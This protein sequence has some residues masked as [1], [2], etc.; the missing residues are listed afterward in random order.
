MKHIYSYL[1]IIGVLFLTFTNKSFAQEQEIKAAA[2]RTL[3][4]GDSH[5]KDALN[6]YM[7]ASQHIKREIP[8]INYVRDIK[9]AQL[10]V[11]TTRQRT[12]SWGRQTNFF[13]EGQLDMAGRKDTLKY[14]SSPDDTED[15]IREG[16]I[17]TLKMGLMR[18]I[19]ETPLAEYIDIK[20]TE[21]ISEVVSDDKWDSWVFS[22]FLGGNAGGESKRFSY[23]ANTGLS[24]NR[25]TDE[26]R[27]STGANYKWDFTQYYI[28]DDTIKSDRRN[29]GLNVTLVKSLSEHFSAGLFTSLNTSSYNN[30]KLNFSLFPAIEYNIF[31]YS[32][33]TRRQLRL[34]YGLG[35]GYRDYHE[36]TIYDKGQ[37]TLFSH[38]VWANYRLIQKWGSINV[39]ANWANYLHDWSKNHLT[40]GLGFNFRIVKGLNLHFGGNYTRVRDQLALVKGG[41][42]EQEI[43]LHIKQLETSFNYRT[44]FG[45]S[46]TFGSIYSNV[47]NPRFGIGDDFD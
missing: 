2:E 31:P 20:F 42:T 11:I 24:A 3:S 30:F 15:E 32:E 5:R 26:W 19:L 38:Q 45:I 44:W 34:V 40:A 6:V 43:L 27:I 21:P 41:A 33:S 7:D 16:E 10:V 28:Q 1:L 39:H 46:Y 13:L 8:Y 22:T 14:I 4:Q 18:Y 9:E 25:V 23:E 29:G 37:E 12:G 17:R 36:I 35:G 47:V